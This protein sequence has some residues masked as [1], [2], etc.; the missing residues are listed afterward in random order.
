MFIRVFV[1]GLAVSL[2]VFVAACG[3][4]DAEEGGGDTG[5]QAQTVRV[6]AADFAFT[7][8]SIDAAPGDEVT[9]TLANDDDTEH[10]FTIDDGVIDI[11][12]EGG[13]SASGTFTVP[14]GGAEFYCKYHPDKM[15]GNVG[16]GSDSG[17]GGNGGG[18]Y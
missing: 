16:G 18:G 13:E 17:S 10:S 3:D 15:H 7:P 11:E 14:D 5:G 8:T 4:D 9:I 2:F 6:T 12:A 1:A